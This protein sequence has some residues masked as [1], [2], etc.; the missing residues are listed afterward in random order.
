MAEELGRIEKPEADGFKKGRKLYFVPMMLS[1]GEEDIE[2]DLKIGKYW[3]QVE[4][5][6]NS[7]ISKLGGVSVIFHELIPSSGD[8]ALK[9]ISRLS[10][11]SLK[12]IEGQIAK[13][14][15]IASLEDAEILFEYLDWG[16]CL[17]I[18]LQSQTVF[19]TVRDSYANSQKK[20]SEKMI[21]NINKSLNED[22]SGIMIMMEGHQ[23]QFPP[24]IQV[25]YISPPGLDD[26]KRWLRTREEEAERAAVSAANNEPSKPEGETQP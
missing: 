14:A 15:K 17:S 16:R 5:Q 25:F 3:E 26:L 4:E 1:A 20:R 7:L 9:A 21:E 12:L 2:L 10:R 8:D 22:E 11:D 13:G 19:N 18:G 6:V 23:M 24:D